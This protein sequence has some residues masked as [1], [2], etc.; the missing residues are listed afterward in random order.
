VPDPVWDPSGKARGALASIV[1]DFG[2]RAL[3]SPSILDN[4]LH[5]LLPDS[6]KQVSLIVA[7]GGST[8]ASSLQEHVAQGMDAET[9]VRLASAQ[10]AEQT[11]YDA[12]GCRWVTGE[13]AR[14]L[15]YQ[16][17]DVPA[18]ADVPTPAAPTLAPVQPVTPV[19]AG[20][21]PRPDQAPTVLPPDMPAVAPWE[22]VAP[23]AVAGSG[24]PRRR[25]RRVPV[26]IAVVIVVVGGLAIL[27]AVGDKPGSTPAALTKLLPA[28]TSGCTA[29]FTTFKT[30]HG[31]KSRLVCTENAINGAV[32]AYQFDSNADY[33]ASIAAF[34]KAEGFDPSKASGGCPTNRV[35]GDGLTGWH[36]KLYP[37]TSGQQLECFSVSY[38]GSTTALQ[39]AYLWTAPSE[40]ALFQAVCGKQTSMKTVDTWWGNHA[41]P[42]V[43]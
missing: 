9:A 32:F 31:I 22:A 25:S 36:S 24:A 13:F 3:S 18:A 2:T 34:N 42:F 20:G 17:S 33:Q 40:N 26:L 11:P 10:L 37:S 38:S 16:V 23:V 30:L 39:P 43:K 15:G 27:G 14:A 6:P 12:A 7:A 35:D 19:V 5:D 29:K 28:G 1:S 21:T 41:G 4:V 8:V